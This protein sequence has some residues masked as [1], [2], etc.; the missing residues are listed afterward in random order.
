MRRLLF[1][2][3]FVEVG[4]LLA[5]QQLGATV[6]YLEPQNPNEYAPL[7]NQFVAQNYDVIVTVGF[8]LADATTAA[9]KANPNVKFIGVDQFQA[10]PA[11]PNLAGLVFK[12]DICSVHLIHPQASLRVNS[13]PK[14]VLQW[15]A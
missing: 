11:L 3:F 14:E 10:D 9:A 8:A 2:A 13:S 4:L 6:S 5:Q 15:W 12:V 7:I 1:V